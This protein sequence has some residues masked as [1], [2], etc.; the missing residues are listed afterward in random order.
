VEANLATRVSQRLAAEESLV[1]TRQ[2][3]GLT[4]GLS[5]EQAAALPAPSDALPV[6]DTPPPPE[7]ASAYVDTAL[8]QRTDARASRLRQQS[9]D[10]LVLAARNGLRPQLDLVMTGGWNSYGGITGFSRYFPYGR[11]VP[12][13][14]LSAGVVVG[15]PVRNRAAEGTYA[16]Q[17]GVAR[18]SEIQAQDVERQIGST[19]RVA[20]SSLES[21]AAQM[22]SKN[23]ASAIYESAVLDEREKL[24]H[25]TGT[26]IDLILTEDRLTQSAL[27]ALSTQINMAKAVARLRFETGSLLGPEA[28]TTVD[29]T[30]LT[31]VPPVTAPPGARRD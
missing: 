27:D 31:T 14:N 30:S 1:E 13:A 22:K 2:S 16:A 12:G 24:R 4:M 20:L 25:G 8:A 15:V 9:Q 26:V 28:Q 3:L 5:G 21:L 7:T 6:I 19:V 17:Q 18:Q 23:E 29:V 11:D 10:R